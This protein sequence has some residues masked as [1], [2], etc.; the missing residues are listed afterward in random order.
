LGSI[1]KKPARGTY[2]TEP[3]GRKDEKK[4]ALGIGNGPP[5]NQGTEK[6]G[7]GPGGGEDDIVTMGE[8]KNEL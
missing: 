6:T 3:A 4:T 5:T 2:K 7:P 1:R 8:K